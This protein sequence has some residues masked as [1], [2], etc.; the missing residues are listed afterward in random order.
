MTGDKV[1]KDKM[2]FAHLSDLEM[3][4]KVRM[5]MRFDLDHEA[6]CTGARDRIM[7]LSQQVEELEQNS[8]SDC[9]NGWKYNRV[10]GRHACSCITEMEPFQILLTALEKISCMSSEFEQSKKI[11][12]EAL[13]LISPIDYCEK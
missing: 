10:E 2:I 8:C 11:A 12:K 3:A 7:Y 6:V 9:D 5:L 4:L 1:E 13:M